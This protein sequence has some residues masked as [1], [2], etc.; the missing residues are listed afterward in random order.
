M[1]PTATSHF[2]MKSFISVGQPDFTNTAS[3]PSAFAAVWTRSTSR[4][5]N[6]PSDFCSANGV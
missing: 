1:P 2:S 6:I 5:S 3:A 4:P